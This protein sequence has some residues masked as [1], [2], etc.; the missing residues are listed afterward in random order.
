[1][2]TFLESLRWLFGLESEE[3]LCLRDYWNEVVIG[4]DGISS[5]RVDQLNMYVDDIGADCVG[6]SDN[7][8]CVMAAGDLMNVPRQKH[9]TL[10]RAYKIA[11][12]SFNCGTA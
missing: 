11:P 2:N 12:R 8:L 5:R 7:G 9:F 10:P 1:M 6:T 3:H 4:R